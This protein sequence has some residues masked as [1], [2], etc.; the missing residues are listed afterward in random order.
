MTP[1]SEPYI[2]IA[3]QDWYADLGSNAR[4]MA[5]EISKTNKVLYVNPPWM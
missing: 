5:M 3:Q 2:L 1:Q 4:N